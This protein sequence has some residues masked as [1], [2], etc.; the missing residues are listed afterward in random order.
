MNH[1]FHVNILSP[2]CPLYTG[3][4]ESLIVPT[5]QG[6]YGIKA[7]HSKMI[8]AVVPGALF[9]RLPGQTAEVISVSHGVVKI[10]NDEVS[11]LVDSL[12]H[13]E[14]IDVNRAKRAADEAKEAML[15]K[16]S[17]QEYRAAQARLVR[18]VN[19]LTVKR[20]YDVIH[21]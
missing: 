5:P 6:K 16:K 7:R 9:Y 17:I 4:C 10:E 14:D 15:Q 1:T 2:D 19:R 8:I 11:V 18:A 12:E 21:Y 3:P 20:K 13:V